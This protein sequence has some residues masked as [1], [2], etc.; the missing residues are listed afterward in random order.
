MTT[1]PIPVIKLE[2]LP[3]FNKEV[4]RLLE[5][6]DS[7]YVGMYGFKDPNPQGGIENGRTVVAFVDGQAVAMASWT[8]KSNG[9]TAVMR[10]MY[11]HYDW[12]GQGISRFVLK[13][14]ELDAS[15]YGCTE[16]WLETGVTQLV[17]INLYASSGY[18][19]IA[20]FGFYA[21]EPTSLFLGKDL[22]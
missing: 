14:L 10:R 13:A 18:T 6:L 3:S 20:P 4:R 7:E 2:I 9:F 1:T 15:F 22:E 11:T 16:M 12:R 5:L 8:R 17:A 19:A 21:G